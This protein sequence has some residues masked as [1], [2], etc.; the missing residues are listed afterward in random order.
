MVPTP[1]DAACTWP[2][3]AGPSSSGLKRNVRVA[4]PAPRA[5][6]S[7]DPDYD[8]ALEVMRAAQRFETWV[9]RDIDPLPSTSGARAPLSDHDDDIPY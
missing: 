8:A 6:T 3:S 5:G 2:A 4:V 9:Y 7:I 1:A